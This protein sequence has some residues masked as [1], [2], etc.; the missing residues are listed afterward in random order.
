IQSNEY[1]LIIIDFMLPD[2][3]G[4]EICRMVRADG[5]VVPIL[6]LTGE[7][8]VETKVTAF[9]AG[10]DDY[11]TKPFAFRELLA[12]IRALLRR[13]SALISDMLTVGDLTLDFSNRVAI[14]KRYIIPLR[15]KEFHILEYLMRNTGQTITREMILDH[16]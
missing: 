14:R 3:D 2:F 10:A 8:H 12:R 6:I 7:D 11:L 1:D 4:V 13:P 16:V 9:E 5:L 15:R